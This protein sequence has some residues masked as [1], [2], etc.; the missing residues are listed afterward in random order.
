MQLW[1]S[2][3]ICC[4]YN[5]SA[6]PAPGQ[7]YSIRLGRSKSSRGPFLDMDGTDLVNGGGY[8]VYGSHSYVYGPG[9][10]GVL[11]NYHGRDVLYYHYGT[12]SYLSPSYAC[13]NERTVPTYISYLDTDKRLGWDYI[14]Y[15]DGW[16]YLVY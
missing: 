7:E 11:Q 1:F 6:L 15:A 14:E 3:G 5:V 16:P 13:A 8:I 9:G 10:E 12:Y 4:G 2:H